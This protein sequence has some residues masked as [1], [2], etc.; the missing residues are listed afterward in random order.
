MENRKHLNGM[1]PALW[2]A[3]G[4]LATV[5]LSGA[6]AKLLPIEII[7]K[8]MPWMGQIPQYFVRLLA[9]VDLMAAVGLLLPDLL[10]TKVYLTTVT[11]YCII[12]LMTCAVVF[13]LIRD[14]ASSIGIN[15]FTASLAVV[16]IWGRSYTSRVTTAEK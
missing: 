4:I 8:E 5:M 7:A 13:H 1:H 16:V 11:A 15:L 2:A 6:V 9:V 10:K 14:E 3:Q 12:T